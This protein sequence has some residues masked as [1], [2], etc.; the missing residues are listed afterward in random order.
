M[1]EIKKQVD[2]I[3]SKRALGRSPLYQRLL[4]YLCEQTELGRLPKEVDIA[5]DV[6]ERQNFDP[7]NDS[8]VRVYLHNLRQK[9]DTYYQELADCPAQRIQIPKGD[10]RLV[11]SAAAAP[12]TVTDD[13]SAGWQQRRKSLL[14]PAAIFAMAIA[15][16]VSGRMT[17]PDVQPDYSTV[18][19]SAVWNKILDDEKPVTI[20]VGDYFV[21]AE[22]DDQ[23][24]SDRLIRDFSIDDADSLD[25]YLKLNPDMHDR[26]VDVRLSYLPLGVGSALESISSVL[27]A[28]NR[29]LQVIPQSEFRTEIVRGGHVIYIGYLSGM[30]RLARYP[31]AVSRLE[32]GMSFDELIDTTGGER[33]VSRAGYVTDADLDYTDY[34]FFSTFPGPAGNRFVIVSGMR[35]E[36]LMRMAS[37]LADADQLRLL[38]DGLP[39]ES[40]T[41]DEAGFEALYKVS[42]L[43]RTHVSAKR[44]F[45]SRL[46][47]SG[48]WQN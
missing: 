16:F 9:L 42:S 33:Y 10:Y 18:A 12:P 20:I 28:A 27:H 31:F 30:G 24:V 2:E 3:I 39:E 44:L 47:A 4:Q 38:E 45:V 11:L 41:D 17:V 35:D 36:G 14:F 19:Q 13:P 26:Y 46:D 29:P 5:A 40:R 15:A 48:I 22:V 43:D 34:G 8:T 1:S 32:I 23:G 6:F 37:I 25:A 7:A 21:F